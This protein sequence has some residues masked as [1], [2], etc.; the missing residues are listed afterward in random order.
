MASL[1]EVA[2]AVEAEEDADV[3]GYEVDSTAGDAQ[4]Q[5]KVGGTVLTK[6]REELEKSWMNFTSM[7][8]APLAPKDPHREGF[9]EKAREKIRSS[10][11][12]LKANG[13][14]WLKRQI[15]F[16]RIHFTCF[17]VVTLI[18]SLVLYLSPN[19]EGGP[20]SFVDSM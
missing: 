7:L 11:E 20:I 1:G 18:G 5:R 17:L 6:T 3:D 8:R 4:D 13:P 19:G 14:A 10:S 15:T 2:R 9:T 12:A 16:Y